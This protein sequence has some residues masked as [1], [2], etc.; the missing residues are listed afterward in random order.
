MN[1]NLPV[2][3]QNVSEEG[4]Y[5]DEYRE[6]LEDYYNMPFNRITIADMESFDEAMQEDANDH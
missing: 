5:D 1:T 3:R 4:I 2:N 6:K